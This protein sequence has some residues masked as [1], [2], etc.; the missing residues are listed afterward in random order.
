MMKF[1]LVDKFITIKWADVLKYLDQNNRAKLAT[2]LD[3]VADNRE[4]DGKPRNNQYIVINEDEPYAYKVVALVKG[5]EIV[6]PIKVRCTGVPLGYDDMLTMGK[7]YE[8]DDIDASGE[9]CI[10]DD[11]GEYNPFPQSLFKVTSI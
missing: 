4:K 11:Q 9:F 7:E 10:E 1:G 8:V 2:I 6:R 3:V 5:Q